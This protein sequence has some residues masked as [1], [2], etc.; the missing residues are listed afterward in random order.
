MLVNIQ[1]A[2]V[3]L[4]EQIAAQDIAYAALVAQLASKGLVDAAVLAT[5]ITHPNVESTS[6]GDASARQYIADLIRFLDT[7]EGP[8]LQPAL[9]LINGGKVD[10]E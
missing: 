8:Q 4:S 6:G 3:T 1:E 10:T 9:Q 5:V 2:L 7:P